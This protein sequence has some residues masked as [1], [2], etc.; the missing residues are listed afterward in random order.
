MQSAR[1][2]GKNR[3]MRRGWDERQKTR[4]T[5]HWSERTGGG[6]GCGGAVGGG[7]LGELGGSR[8]VHA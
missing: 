2:L 4:T 8:S 6:G 1:P 3:P 7:D 5:L